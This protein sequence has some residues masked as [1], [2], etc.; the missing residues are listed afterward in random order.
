[1]IVVDTRKTDDRIGVSGETETTNGRR[2]MTING[3]VKLAAR[4]GATTTLVTNSGERVV[5]RMMKLF[6]N[7]VEVKGCRTYPNPDGTHRMASDVLSRFLF[8][9]CQSMTV[10]T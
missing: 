4:L 1:M 6:K 7:A 2:K 8:S 5:G 9:E 10:E 3:N